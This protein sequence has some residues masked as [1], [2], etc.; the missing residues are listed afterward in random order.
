M[1]I[2][3]IIEDGQT[4]SKVQ[5]LAEARDLPVRQD[6]PWVIFEAVCYPDPE[7][8]LVLQAA[9]VPVLEVAPVTRGAGFRRPKTSQRHA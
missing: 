7:V 3:Q 8:L 9:W 5:A 4:W 1:R 2:L 6:D